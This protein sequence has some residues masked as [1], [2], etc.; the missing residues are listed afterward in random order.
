MR[1]PLEAMGAQCPGSLID[2]AAD[3]PRKDIDV[4]LPL[5]QRQAVAKIEVMRD[6]PNLEVKLLS[7]KQIASTSWAFNASGVT[8]DGSRELLY[9]ITNRTVMPIYRAQQPSPGFLYIPS[10]HKQAGITACKIAV[11]DDLPATEAVALPQFISDTLELANQRKM[12]AFEQQQA[13]DIDD[14]FGSPIRPNAVGE[15]G[16]GC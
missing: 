8:A 7:E 14:M 13:R 6:R 9:S 2:L 3:G 10:L 4:K 12:E 1:R 5:A 16:A 11:L 15:P